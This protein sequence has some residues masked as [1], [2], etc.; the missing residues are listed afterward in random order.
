M[1]PVSYKQWLTIMGSDQYLITSGLLSWGQTSI[2]R[3]VAYYHGDRPVSHK[4]WLTITG[5]DRYLITCGLLTGR[6]VGIYF[7]TSD[8]VNT[9]FTLYSFLI[10]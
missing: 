5:T 9:L 7:T 8:G 3:A 4:H 6:Q 2:T 10:I 1:I